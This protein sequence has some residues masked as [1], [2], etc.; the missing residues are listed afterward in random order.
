MNEIPHSI[1]DNCR[2]WEAKASEELANEERFKDYAE[3]PSADIL[4]EMICEGL[5]ESV[6][7]GWRTEAEAEELY[8]DWIK[9]YRT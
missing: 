8:F 5:K 6:A 2:A 4:Q 1:T 9:K 7:G 3:I